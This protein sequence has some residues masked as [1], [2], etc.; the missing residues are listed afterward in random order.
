VAGSAQPLTVVLVDD[1]PE[2]RELTRLGLEENGGFRVVA[3]ACDGHT[4]LDAVSHERPQALLIDLSMPGMDGLDAIPQVRELTPDVAIV[5]FSGFTADRMGRRAL[6]AGAD[7]YV[8]KGVP[9]E[10]LQAITRE[11]VIERAAEAG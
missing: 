1:V 9:V 6:E 11:A 4:A 10:E 5:V 8:E 2:V 7:R 3:E